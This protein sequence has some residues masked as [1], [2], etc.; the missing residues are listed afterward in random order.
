MTSV[1]S[2]AVHRQPVRTMTRA[3]VAAACLAALGG[4]ALFSKENKHP[5]AEL[6]PVS[7][8]LTVRQAWKADVGK[9]GPYSMQPAAAGNNVYVSSNNGNVMALEGASG[10]VLWKAKTDL[11]L[12]SG[13]GSDGSVTAVAGEKGAIYAFDASGKQIWKKQVNGEV[14]SAPLVGNGLVVVRTTDT[15][16]FGLDAETGERRWIYQRSQTPLN[17]RAAMGMAFAGDGIVMGF[18]GGKLGVLTPGNGVLRWE[19]TISYPKGVSEIERLNDV[20]GQPM[21]SGRQVCATT[22]QGRVACLELATGQPQWGKDFSS[23]SGPAQD[24]NAIYASDERSVVH[25]FDRQNGSERWKNDQMRNRRLGAPLALG[26]SVVMGD[27]EGYVHFLSREDGQV[28]ARM[29][30]DGSAIT[31]APV[32][33]GQTLVIQTRDGD[34]FGFQPG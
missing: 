5:P 33:A 23:P 1:L 31:A 13:P 22:F 20:T 28:V 6:K 14:L 15:R 25:A 8:T 29:K 24:D 17:L 32:V 30:T 18:P 10:R 19:S 16:V 26:R 12:T 21:I 27:F 2:R 34:V 7:A 4:C 3:L 9:S 11:D